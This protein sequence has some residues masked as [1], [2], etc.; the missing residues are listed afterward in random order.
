MNILDRDEE[1][2]YKR[3]ENQDIV[4]CLNS[5]W[6]PIDK[7]SIKKALIDMNS[8]NESAAVGLDIEYA[9]DENGEYLFD[10]DPISI[11][12]VKWENWINLPIRDYDL[13]IRTVKQKIRV[14]TV[15]ILVN[16]SKMPKRDP[17]PTPSAIW[18]RD[19]YTCQYTGKK[20]TR[21]TGNIDHIIPRDLWKRQNRPGSP[22]TW[23][24]MVLSCKSVNSSKG[25]R[26]NNEAGLRL[27]RNPR[28]P[29]PI[30]VS[31][32]ITKARHRDWRYFI[33][34]K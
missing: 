17:K 27:I 16:Y 4:L 3:F 11:T 9:M 23:E 13:V 33:T 20:L 25:N 32:L 31:A 18:E 5:V 28:A 6:Q 7:K 29:L 15:I 19:N 30:P 8:Q 24:N 26:T 2:N 12:P 21:K 22:D 14:P 1:T 34:E 10:S